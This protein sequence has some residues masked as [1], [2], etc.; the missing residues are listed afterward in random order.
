MKV[1]LRMLAVAAIAA[2]VLAACGTAEP[3][4]DGNG[5]ASPGASTGELTPPDENASVQEKL[6]WLAESGLEGEARREFL[7]EQAAAAG[8]VGM[9]GS[10]DEEILNDWQARLDEEFPE[11]D[12]QIVRTQEQFER[13]RAESQAGQPF[14]SVFDGDP[15]GMALA[16]E[17]GGFFASYFS[18]EADDFDVGISGA[19]HPDGLYTVHSQQPMVAF[20][21][22]DLMTEDEMP[23]T[24]EE[25]ADPSFEAN[26]ARSRFG[27]RWLAAMIQAYGEDRAIE[28]AEGIASKDY[29]ITDSNTAAREAVIVGQ[30]PFGI[31]TQFGGILDMMPTGAP[32]NW[33]LIEP[34]FADVG[35][36]SI[37]SDAPN[38][39]GAVLVYD[40]ILSAD[41]GQTT[42][43]GNSL[44]PRP[45]M[46]YE[47]EGIGHLVGE[48]IGYTP[49][50]LT[51]IGPIEEKW[52][53]L[54]VR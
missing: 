5:A 28:I 48:M 14:A 49:Q 10:L 51:D 40:W 30:A 50:L 23:D 13:V 25:L 9:Y 47:V 16:L 1:P 39:Y 11:L 7:V 20:Y 45:D 35:T 29:I 36:V 42:F 22:T 37:M 43:V 53:E 12:I 6:D 41:G 31:D 34:V 18:P 19:V 54:F 38:P 3:T 32:I 2:L 44:G 46:D 52:Q 8:P 17:E 15:G 24:Y 33:H 4:D 26:F 21:N 27:E